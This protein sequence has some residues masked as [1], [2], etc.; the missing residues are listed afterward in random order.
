MAIEI[1]DLYGLD[2]P[3][4]IHIQK[5]KPF[6]NKYIR[7]IKKYFP[8][9]TISLIVTGS[10]GAIIAGVIATKVN[11]EIIY[12]K[13]EGEESH[14]S[15]ADLPKNQIKIIVDDF[16]QTGATI[17]RILNTFP[18]LIFDALIVGGSIDTDAFDFNRFNYI[19]CR[20]VWNNS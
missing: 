4:G 7:I 1:R 6:I 8:D 11:C 20:K 3:V 17:Q 19:F 13:K 5:N 9:R 18:L 10:S 14:A 12:V 2:Y 15:H 16:V